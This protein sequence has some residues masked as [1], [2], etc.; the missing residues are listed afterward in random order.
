MWQ[1]RAGDG[2][3]Q[4][5]DAGEDQAEG[6]QRQQRTAVTDQRGQQAGGILRREGCS[7]VS[8]TFGD[9]VGYSHLGQLYGQ[10]FLQPTSGMRGL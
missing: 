7:G 10:S 8:G 1:E 2:Q 5:E 4:G 3:K 9:L 6:Y